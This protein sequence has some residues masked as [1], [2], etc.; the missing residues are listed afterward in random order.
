[1]DGAGRRGRGAEDFAFALVD[2]ALRRQSATTGAFVIDSLPPYRISF[3]SACVLEAVAAAWER[4]D[5]ERA[6]RYAQAWH[7]GMRFVERLVI[8]ERDAFFSPVP[9]RCAGGVRATLASAHVRIDFP[10]H[11]LLAL[12]KGAHAGAAA[13]ATPRASRSPAR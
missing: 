8:H 2:W 1:V 9:E 6:A 5:G 10:G 11:A 13:T 12:A 7:N 3:L 4:A